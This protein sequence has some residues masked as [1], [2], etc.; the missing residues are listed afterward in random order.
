MSQLTIHVSRTAGA[1]PSRGGGEQTRRMAGWAL[2]HGRVP[3]TLDQDAAPLDAL[4]LMREPALADTDLHPHPV[5]VLHLGIDG[6]THDEVL[7]ACG[8]VP[9]EEILGDIRACASNEALG[10][11][12]GR[13]HP[14]HACTILGGDGPEDA[15]HA[16][17]AAR[18]HYFRM[19]GCLE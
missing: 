18:T 16:L 11:A 5:G 7:C 12:V 3:D 2:G 14:Y 19:T 17:D 13:L 6:V 9:A 15:E 8:E 4:V 1:G 10:Q